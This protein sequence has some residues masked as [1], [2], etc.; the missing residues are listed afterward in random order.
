MFHSGPEVD[1][2]VGPGRKEPGL[3]GVPAQVHH[4]KVVVHGVTPGGTKVSL[5]QEGT[6]VSDREK[7][8]ESELIQNF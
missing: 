1:I 7:N 4:A 6:R 8:F 2:T 3:G 5:R